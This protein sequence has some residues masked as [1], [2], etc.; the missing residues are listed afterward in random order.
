MSETDRRRSGI[1]R[2]INDLVR[3]RDGSL[4]LTK[5]GTML[6]QW[7]SIKLILENGSA[8]IANWDSL[9]VLFMVLLAP[10]MLKKILT[11]KYGGTDVQTS[12][13]VTETRTTTN[14]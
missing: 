1:R 9:T 3:D 7:L 10:E 4:S 12:S 11:W 6:A 5:V 8:I 2:D 14:K 13:S